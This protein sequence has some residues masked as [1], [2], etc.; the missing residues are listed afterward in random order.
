VSGAILNNF[1][2][3]GKKKEASFDIFSVVCRRLIGKRRFGLKL[4]ISR[5]ATMARRLRMNLANRAPNMPEYH[6]HMLVHVV[7]VSIE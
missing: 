2:L 6:C 7:T 5:R 3:V 1:Y 4:K